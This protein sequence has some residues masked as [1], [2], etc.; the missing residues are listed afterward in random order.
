M[1]CFFNLFF[2]LLVTGWGLS[3][4]EK[5]S[6]PEE[7]TEKTD[8]KLPDDTLK[9]DVTGEGS[10][11]APATV[12]DL[13]RRESEFM[14]FS[15]WVA[16]YIVGYTERTMSN[17]FFGAE[18]A[19]QSNILLADYPWCEDEEECVPVEL[20]TDKWKQKLS[21]AHSPSNLGKRIAVHGLIETYFG[22]IGV[23]S[24]DEFRWMAEDSVGQ[25][26]N[27]DEEDKPDL[28][29]EPQADPEDPE[30]DGVSGDPYLIQMNNVSLQWVDRGSILLPGEHYMLGTLPEQGE[31]VFVAAS[32]K[33]GF[34]QKYRSVIK[35]RANG[36]C[37]IT[38]DGRAPA[39]FTL[40]KSD[41]GYCFRDDLS[42][43]YLAYDV[44]GDASSVSWISLYTLLP[45]DLNER[46]QSA[47][48]IRLN[49]LDEQLL[50]VGKIKFSDI[51][52]RNCLLRYNLGGENFK[53]NYGKS[54]SPV[55]LFLLK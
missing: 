47:F 54:G 38:E 29:D 43:A 44:R 50:T 36:S 55:Y 45:E 18:D 9:V 13:L 14:G 27:S 52:S 31:A 8:T 26:D 22:V 51:D 15:C 48:S 10:V 39:V 1:R 33:Y 37:W 23:R 21:L 40:E 28:P 42:G 53:L 6:F 20:K 17:A 16:G 11:S 41:E 24:M 7:S 3:G 5:I 35:V 19:V 32:M 12:G 49:T 34:S 25:P 4:C 30:E 46:Y 2:L